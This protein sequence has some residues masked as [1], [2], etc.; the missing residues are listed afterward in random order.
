MRM[1]SLGHHILQLFFSLFPFFSPP[2][3]LHFFFLFLFYFFPHFFPFFVLFL[4]SDCQTAN[5]TTFDQLIICLQAQ[6]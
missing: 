4:R 5:I 1:S 3:S 6:L 2:L